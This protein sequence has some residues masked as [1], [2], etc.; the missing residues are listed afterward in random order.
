MSS[1]TKVHRKGTATSRA[2]V[3]V[4]PHCRGPGLKVGRVPVIWTQD[5][6]GRGSKGDFQR[7]WNVQMSYVDVKRCKGQRLIY[8]EHYCVLAQ[9]PQPLV[10]NLD[11]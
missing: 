9:G 4:V 6:Y 5:K 1:S 10:H 2:P 3:W 8:Q 7:E 11:T